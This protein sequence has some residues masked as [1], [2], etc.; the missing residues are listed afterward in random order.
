MAEANDVYGSIHENLIDAG[1]DTQT[2]E[3]CMALV[4][5]G[6]NSAILPILLQHRK[7]LLETV[8]TG[9]KRIDCLDFL[10]YKIKNQTQVKEK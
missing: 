7:D 8:H 5:E 9:Q 6:R 4:K 10:V 3:Q 2:T 1:C